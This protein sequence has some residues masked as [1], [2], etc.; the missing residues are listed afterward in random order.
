MPK[1]V[2]TGGGTAGHV[3]LNLALIPHLRARGIDVA[4]I[5]SRDGLER[6]LLAAAAPD[7][8]YYAV[9]TGKLRRYFDWQNFKDPF[10]VAA[11]VVEA[12]RLLGRLRP[13]VVFSKG[14]FVAV[15]VVLAARLRGL[16]VVAHESDL[17]PG[18]A[19]RIALPFVREVL[20]T[21]PETKARLKHP[22]VRLVGGVVREALFDGRREEGRR[23]CGFSSPEDRARSGR[24]KPVLLVTGGSLGARKLNEAL[25]A[26]LDDFLARYAI[27]HLTGEQGYDPSLRRPGYCQ[28]AFAREELPHLFAAAD[29]AVSRAGANTIFEL[30]ALGIPMLLVPLSRAQSRGDQI[31]NARSFERR[32]LARVLPDEAVTPEAL[33]QAVTALEAEAEAIRRRLLEARDGLIARP[34][35]VADVIAAYAGGTSPD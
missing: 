28:F 16:P 19:N 22:R 14:G 11:G 8:P 31:E 21:F 13:D 29:L 1:A 32:G 5:G 17:T 18:L 7:V 15:P 27:I 35:A 12:A 6:R 34:E 10:R 4:Y 24:A 23:L 30:A 33:L 2:L 20:V 3:M 25:R 26:R 9:S